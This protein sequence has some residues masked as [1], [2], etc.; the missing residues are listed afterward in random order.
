VLVF[1]LTLAV[2]SAVLGRL[3]GLP[4]AP[5]NGSTIPKMR[6]DELRLGRCLAVAV[7]FS[8]V[9]V[10]LEFGLEINKLGGF[11]AFL[12]QT[13]AKAEPIVQSLLDTGRSLPQGITIHDVARAVT[14]AQMPIG[15]AAGVVLLVFNL[16]LA[17]RIALTSGL[18]ASA[19]PDIPRC[20]RMPRPLA[21]LLAVALGL[22][23]AG[24]LIGMAS[25]IVS[26]ALLMSF[27]MQGLAVIHATT[28]GKSFR[29]PA[30]II[31]YLLMAM[32]LP[33]LIVCLGLLGLIDSA[34]ALR[35]RPT[36]AKRYP[37]PW[38]PPRSKT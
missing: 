21:L 23:F 3:A 15:S 25:L 18:L 11:A 30:L 1:A 6:P 32:L 17:G 13:V 10:L 24:G 14:W 27:A 4:V 22:S 26:G 12:T 28:R 35:D 19:W 37:G 5:P 2:P 8:A 33:W 16:W 20:T 34:F 29:L 9:G 31:L 38:Q 36:K 7:G